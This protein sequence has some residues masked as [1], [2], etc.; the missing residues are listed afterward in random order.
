MIFILESDDFPLRILWLDPKEALEY[1]KIRFV[2]G[3]RQDITVNR[4]TGI[5]RDLFK[6]LKRGELDIRKTPDVTFYGEEGI[7]AKGLTKEF[8]NL[9]MSELKNGRGYMIFE[10]AHDHLVPVISEEYLNSGFFR[11]VGKLIAMSTLHG[12]GGFIGLSRAVAMYLI[13]DDIDVSSCYLSFEDIPDYGSQEA[14]REVF[15]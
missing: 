7:D 8:F 1:H 2:D 6:M 3:Q 13:T 15:H 14:L 11:Y 10:G 9:V 4:H 12:G 5:I